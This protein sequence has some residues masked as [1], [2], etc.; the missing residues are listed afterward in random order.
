M[1]GN[2]GILLDSNTEEV[3]ALNQALDRLQEQDARKAKLMEMIYFGGLNC[4]EAALVLEV[5]VATVNRE[6]KVAKAWLKHELRSSAGTGSQS[7]D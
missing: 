6:V 7:S 1:V 4:D 3:L 2:T 5:S